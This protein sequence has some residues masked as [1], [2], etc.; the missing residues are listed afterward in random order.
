[1]NLG[2]GSGITQRQSKL[3]DRGIQAMVEIDKSVGGPQTSMKLF[4]RHNLAGTFEQRHQKLQ[5]LIPQA[6]FDPAVFAQFSRAVAQFKDA[7]TEN[8]GCHRREGLLQCG[9]F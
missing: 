6:G 9:P 4:A 3:V 8:A 2:F 5:R 1:M 7:K